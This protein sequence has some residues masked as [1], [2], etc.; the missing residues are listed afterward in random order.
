MP[1]LAAAAAPLAAGAATAGTAAGTAAAGAGAA[2]AGAGLG[3]A[4]AGLGAAG[5]TAL[6]A[7]AG[8]IGGGLGGIGGSGFGA[9]PIAES[10]IGPS[11]GMSSGLANFLMPKNLTEGIQNAQGLTGLMGAL[12][13]KAQPASPMSFSRGQAP[14]VQLP[15]AGTQQ[16]I[17]SLVGGSG[18]QSQQMAMLMQ[19]LAQ[20]K[21]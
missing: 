7:G 19:L 20:M 18:G 17:P 5:T 14:Q 9:A 11:G 2:G 10:S 21:R 3:A 16:K 13:P 6:D 8:P 1:P 15:G 12:M 4:G